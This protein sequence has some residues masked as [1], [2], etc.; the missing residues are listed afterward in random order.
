MS[1]SLVA[2]TNRRSIILD[3]ATVPFDISHVRS[4]QFPFDTL[5]RP[6]FPSRGERTFAIEE[7]HPRL[8]RM[9]R[10]ANRSL[11]DGPGD[12]VDRGIG[13]R[14]RL[15]REG[16]APVITVER[17]EGFP[18][19]GPNQVKNRPPDRDAPVRLTAS[20]LR[21][22][23]PATVKVGLDDGPVV[24]QPS[25]GDEPER[26]GHSSVGE[27]LGPMMV[28]TADV[29]Q[30]AEKSQLVVGHLAIPPDDRFDLIHRAR[31]ETAFQLEHEEVPHHV[32]PERV[33]C[34]V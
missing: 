24:E 22:R 20:L 11:H 1:L 9:P 17:R 4:A 5:G 23:N 10:I 30:S 18:A 15:L 25:L 28:R 31:P 32:A 12:R 19:A 14:G 16:P 6:A 27:L 2:G 7:G 13:Q 29:A 8:D 34:L 33:R 21:E 3:R 26:N